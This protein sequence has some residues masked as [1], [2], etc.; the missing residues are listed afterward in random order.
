MEG[1][2]VRSKARLPSLLLALLGLGPGECVG[3]RRRHRAFVPWE[4]RGGGAGGGATGTGML[5]PILPSAA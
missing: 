2:L 1:E 4:H 5:T 3:G